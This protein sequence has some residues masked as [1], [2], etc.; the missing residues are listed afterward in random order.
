MSDA[1]VLDPVIQ[2]QAHPLA[3][4]VWLILA[5][6]SEA[7]ARVVFTALVERLRPVEDGRRESALHAMERCAAATGVGRPS[8]ARYRKWRAESPEAFGAPTVAQ[9]RTIFGGKWSLATEALPG[10][11]ASDVLAHRLTS[12]RGPFSPQDCVDALRLWH[13]ETGQTLEVQYVAWSRAQ[14]AVDRNSRL[15]ATGDPFRLR[16]D[17]WRDALSAAGIAYERPAPGH[18]RFTP[19]HPR[20]LTRDE[21]I[22]ALRQAHAAIGEPFTMERYNAWVRRQ[23]AEHAERQERMRIPGHSPAVRLFGSW[24]AATIEALGDRP[25]ARS[26]TCRR[27][28][29]YTRDDLAR[30]W[31]ACRDELGRTPTMSD[32]EHWR[33]VTAEANGFADWPPS[34]ASIRMRLGDARW[35]PAC[36]LLLAEGQPDG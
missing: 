6:R 8:A 7:D 4:R 20:H 16:F 5:H 25:Q 31:W 22:A 23:A 17:G 11:A 33:H 28:R 15:P 24:P 30:A 29:H 32:Y 36:T 10:V 18:R 2:A 35:A 34:E 19:Q 13:E 27:A 14:R 3:F 21:I 1:T 9:V 12:P 26:Q